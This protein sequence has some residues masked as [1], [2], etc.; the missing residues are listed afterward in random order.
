MSAQK[1]C[2]QWNNLLKSEGIRRFFHLD[3]R[4]KDPDAPIALLLGYREFQ[5]LAS[6]TGWI[7]TLDN[8]KSV[9]G[10]IAVNDFI[11]CGVE[12]AISYR[13]SLPPVTLEE[14]AALNEARKELYLFEYGNLRNFSPSTTESVEFARTIWLKYIPRVVQG[15]TLLG[16][17]GLIIYWI[18]NSYEAAK[19]KSHKEL[20]EALHLPQNLIQD[21]FLRQ[22]ICS[23][24]GRVPLIPVIDKCNHLFDYLCIRD[25]IARKIECPIT[26]KH[27][28]QDD[29]ELDLEAF[30]NIQRRLAALKRNNDPLVQGLRFKIFHFPEQLP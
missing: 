17:V 1:V 25:H 21:P 5:A 3:T 18:W 27:L 29:I 8:T 22:Y 16:S 26:H 6:R 9:S 7:Q 2:K 14:V 23:I 4:W 24:S 10:G 15:I 13:N 28:T 19:Q 20:V 11:E 30:T 12:K